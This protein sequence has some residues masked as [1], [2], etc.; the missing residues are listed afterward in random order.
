M[1]DAFICEKCGQ[2]AD[3]HG[4]GEDGWCM[5]CYDKWFAAEYAYWKPLYDG[6]KQAG[7]LWKEDE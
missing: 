1:S 4:P 5:A 3:E 2:P 6:E 7:L